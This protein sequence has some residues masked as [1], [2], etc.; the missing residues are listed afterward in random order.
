M[1]QGRGELD[2]IDKIFKLLGVPNNESWP[3]FSSLPNSGTFRWKN[4]EGSRLSKE[5]PV[6]SFSGAGQSFL[7]SNG[8]DLLQKLLTM[9]PKKRIT[10][11]EAIHHP[12]FFEGIDRK[13]P[14]FTT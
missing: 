13:R 14:C 12:Y 7:D 2:Q 3:E 6:G 10:A 11:T 4:K 9:N 1:L 8:F 5:F